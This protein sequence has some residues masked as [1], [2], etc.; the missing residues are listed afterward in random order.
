MDGKLYK[1]LRLALG[2]TTSELSEKIGVGA[3]YISMMESGKRAVSELQSRKII[4]LLIEAERNDDAC[5]AELKK[6]FRKWLDLVT[7]W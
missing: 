5:F 1:R 4:E 2:L 3:N 6:I 7:V